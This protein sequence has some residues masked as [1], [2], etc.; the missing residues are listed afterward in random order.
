MHEVYI[1]L[2]HKKIDASQD[3]ISDFTLS[4]RCWSLLLDREVQ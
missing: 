1:T 3:L 2:Q 4:N